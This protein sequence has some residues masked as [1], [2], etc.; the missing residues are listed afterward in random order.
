MIAPMTVAPAQALA[1]VRAIPG[2][3]KDLPSK[4]STIRFESIRITDS[5]LFPGRYE[6]LLRRA[7]DGSFGALVLKQLDG[8]G[9]A[10]Q[11]QFRAAPAAAGAEAVDFSLEAERWGLPVG[12]KV[13]WNEA[14]AN[15]RISGRIVEVS[16][17]SLAG[18]FGVTTGTLMAA[19]DTEWAVTGTIG[20]ANIDVESVLQTLRPQGRPA[21]D[22]TPS[23][24]QGTANLNLAL[25]GHGSTLDEAL[26]RSTVAG[27]F[28]IRWATLN[29]VNLG[30]AATQGATAAGIT[31]FT[32][33]DGVLA[34]SASGVRFEETGGR[35]GAMS[36]RGDFTVAPDLAVA[37][38]VRVELGG[39]TV[40][41]PVNLRVRGS[42]LDPR[43]TR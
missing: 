8:D 12:P 5:R 38:A 11:M 26:A 24:I 10:M 15:G 40:Q 42:A 43:F 9:G 14:R 35:A 41:A 1:A 2:R 23:S 31:R 28:Q 18:F 36:A 16:S 39:Q 4:I 29:G 34:A 7:D 27:S 33:F 3:A 22:G 37:G 30:L 17:F 20:A 21:A 19:H 6:A 25:A 13:R 32:E